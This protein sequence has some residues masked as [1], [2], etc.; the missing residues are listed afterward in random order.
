VPSLTTARTLNSPG[1]TPAGGVTW[2][3]TVS[4]SSS[5]DNSTGIDVGDTFHPVGTSKVTD[6][7]A[8]VFCPF[9]TTTRIS[10]DVAAAAGLVPA[11]PPSGTIAI[12]G[13]TPTEN[14]GTT[15]NSIRFSPVKMFPW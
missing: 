10:R 4:A 12:D 15:S 1:R 14:R 8:G 9:V 11:E 3:R 7:F 5:R 13:D 2:N 6:A